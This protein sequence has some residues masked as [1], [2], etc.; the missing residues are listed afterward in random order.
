MTAT[1]PTCG[2]KVATLAALVA[3]ETVGMRGTLVFAAC[4]AWHFGRGGDR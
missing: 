3:R 4:Y 1:C 2:S